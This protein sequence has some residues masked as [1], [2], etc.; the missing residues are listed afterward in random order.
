MENK[1]IAHVA[2]VGGGVA[3]WMSAA[4]LAQMLGDGVTVTVAE[5]EGCDDGYVARASLPPIKAVHATLG[6]AETDV[7]SATQGSMK[8]GTQFVNWGQLGNRYFHPHG[9]YGAEFDAAPLHQWWLKEKAQHPD[10]P[11]IDHLSLACA[12]AQD[13]RFTHPVPDRRMIQSS[14][15]YGYHMDNALYVDLL[16]KRALAQGV[17]HLHA[18]DIGVI[19][20][21][22]TGIIEGV[23][24]GDGQS[25]SADLFLDCTG[26]KA[27]LI[28]QALEVSFED[29][30]AY[31]PCDRIMNVCTARAPDFAPNTRVTARE[32]GWHWRIPLQH[33][34]SFGYVFASSYCS[35]EDA[36][37][38]LLENIDGRPLA[39][40][41]V[42]SFKNGR[43]QNSFV[44]NVVA[45]GEAAGFLEPLEAT[46]VQVIQSALSRLLALWPSSTNDPLVA[47]E[48][49]A[50]SNDDWDLARDFLVLHYHLGS[51]AESPLWR[52]CSNMAIPDSLTH[53]LAHWHHG[54][55]LVSPKAEVF[56]ASSWLSV[57]V[58]QGDVPATLNPLVEARAGQ[59]DYLARLAG[60][61]SLIETTAP[62][63]PN[64]RD[65]IEKHARA[66]RV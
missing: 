45:I 7:L 38:S 59:V 66:P 46:S 15:D 63:L 50:V 25:L 36:A 31:L 17:K 23:T 12:L 3:A 34:T 24:L 55:R 8:L 62:T 5:L 49:N 54:A 51:R 2:I 27:L 21:G 58:G 43:R 19:Q 10:T 9:T 42:T 65:W 33:R 44:G 4:F 32:A 30:S 47:H 16:R 41:I 13:G 1:S 28:G 29:W 61:R 35:D 52:Y 60:L 39:D 20:Q 64:H 53:R 57:L 40:P 48:Y 18:T 22:D 56:Q 26:Q 11:G 14:L 37:G 6:L